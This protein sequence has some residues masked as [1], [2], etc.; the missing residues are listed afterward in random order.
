MKTIAPDYYKNFRC[1]ADKCRHTCCRGW[2]I[3]IDDSALSRFADVKEISS[4]IC[5]DNTPHFMLT[6]DESCPFLREDG[7]CSMILDY[8]EDMLCDICRDHPRFRNYWSD[9]VEIGTGLVCEEAARLILTQKN[10]MRLVVIDDDGVEETLPEDEAWLL[11][12]RDRMLSQIKETGPRARL[13]EYLIYRHIPDT[14]Y[15]DRLEERTAFVFSAYNEIVS[16]WEKTDGSIDSLI[17]CA[18]KFSYDVE[19]DDEVLE[20]RIAAMSGAS[21]NIDGN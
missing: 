20:E 19:Y 10:P 13:L 16:E 15:D 21:G 6:E 2:E 11:G 14:L 8:G 3:D 5:F 12:Y 9:R 18:R 17:E 1:T 4:R 7:L